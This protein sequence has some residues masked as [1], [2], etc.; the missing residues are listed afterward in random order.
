M[1]QFIGYKLKKRRY[2]FVHEQKDEQSPYIFVTTS[3]I[4]LLH[5][6]HR[7]VEMEFI[8]ICRHIKKSKS[9]SF[10]VILFKLVCIS[11]CHAHNQ[12]LI[13]HAV[14]P[15]KLP[16]FPFSLQRIKIIIKYHQSFVTSV[17]L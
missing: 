14:D 1:I 8:I 10:V 16:F 12:L 3:Q 2:Y 11:S 9:S 17:N 6:Q 13:L 7:Y 4:L 5:F 15:K